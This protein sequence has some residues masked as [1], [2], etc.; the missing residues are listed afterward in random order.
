MRFNA[1]LL[2]PRRRREG[3]CLCVREKVYFYSRC[4]SLPGKGRSSG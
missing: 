4:D 2:S 3:G 1:Q